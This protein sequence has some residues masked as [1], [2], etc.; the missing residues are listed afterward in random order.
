MFWDKKPDPL[1]AFRKLSIALNIIFYREGSSKVSH[2]IPPV[3][4]IIV[5]SHQVWKK[6]S[7]IKDLRDSLTRTFA[8]RGSR[9]F[10]TIPDSSGTGTKTIR[11]R[12]SF[13]RKER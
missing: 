1:I 7:T 4:E 8:V 13:H 5:V 12:A 3:E 6:R 11:G 10:R 9:H 2:R